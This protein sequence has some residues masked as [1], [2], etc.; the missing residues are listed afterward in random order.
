MTCG[1]CND[2]KWGPM[3][4]VFFFWRYNKTQQ[5]IKGTNQQMTLVDHLVR[6]IR[7]DFVGALWPSHKL[8]SY[9]DNDIAIGE[10]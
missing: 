4:N 3:T 8:K 1:S 9:R 10:M 6:C 7:R 5:S 2:H